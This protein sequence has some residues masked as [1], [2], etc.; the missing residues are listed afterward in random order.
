MTREGGAG[1]GSSLYTNVSGCH[2]CPL[3]KSL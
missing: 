1:G 2:R 3:V